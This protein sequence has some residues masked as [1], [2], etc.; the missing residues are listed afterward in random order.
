MASLIMLLVLDG[1][2]DD[3]EDLD[4]E[5]DAVGLDCQVVVTCTLVGA[6]VVVETLVVWAGEVVRAAV[7]AVVTVV[8]EEAL[9]H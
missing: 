5:V 1:A 3:A 7:V 4:V 2:E 9:T 6:V 8:V